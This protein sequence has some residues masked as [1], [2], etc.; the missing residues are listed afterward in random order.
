[1]K[2]REERLQAERARRDK[3]QQQRIERQATL[4]AKKLGAC[5]SARRSRVGCRGFEWGGSE[6]A[7]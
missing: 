2:R 6:A 3:I 7:T 5:Q 4:V 1:M